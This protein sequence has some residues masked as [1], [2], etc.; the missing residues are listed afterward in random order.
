VTRFD[1]KAREALLDTG[2]HLADSPSG[3]TLEGLRR[4]GAPFKSAKYFEQHASLTLE[5]VFP[6]GDIAYR[7][8]L[9]PESLNQPYD[10]C[11]AHLARL[12]PLLPAG[13]QP[14]V[15]PAALYV[16]LFDDHSRR[17]GEWLL[18]KC[19]TWTA[20]QCRLGNMSTHLV[21]GLFGGQR[22]LVVSPLPEGR[23]RGVGL[24]P[25][26]VPRASDGS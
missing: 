14:V 4:S 17:T 11:L 13:A 7:P 12:I 2:W 1:A 24:M 10:R 9:M 6:G 18:Q 19:F 20:D 26:V 15:A 5:A 23:G 22:P 8:G 3:L 16:W 25:V 21:V